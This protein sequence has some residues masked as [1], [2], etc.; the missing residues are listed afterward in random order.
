[1]SII[2]ADPFQ[3]LADPTRRALLMAVAERPRPVNE[4][5][6]GFEMSRPGVSKHLRILAGAGL[7]RFTPGVR[8]ARQRI[9]H[10]EL[11]AVAQLEA[12]LE[13]LRGF[14][15][16]RLDKLGGVLDGME[17]DVG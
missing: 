9:V 10:A 7:V 1:M 17:D 16:A 2:D 8:D 13:K 14:W 3:A 5:A 6:E 4:L 11:A 12:Y 15:S